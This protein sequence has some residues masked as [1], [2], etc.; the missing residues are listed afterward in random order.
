MQ[1]YSGC[2]NFFYIY[3]VKIQFMKKGMQFLLM[4]FLCISFTGLHAQ[5]KNTY[6]KKHGILMIKAPG[7]MCMLLDRL[8]NKVI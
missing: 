2:T 7:P 1:L 6:K 8:M 5:H 3:H 4:I